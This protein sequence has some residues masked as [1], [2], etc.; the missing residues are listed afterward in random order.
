VHQGPFVVDL[1]TTGVVEP[2]ESHPVALPPGVWGGSVDALVPEGRQVKKGDF[3]ARVSNRRIVEQLLDK[4]DELAREQRGLERDRAD[5]PVKRWDVQQE[6]YDKQQAWRE[7][8]LNQQTALRGGAPEDVAAARRDVRLVDLT[9]ANDP[10][11][12]EERLFEKGIVSRQEL[13]NARR[14]HDVAELEKKRAAIALARLAPGALHEQVELARLDAGMAKAAYE[15]AKLEAPAKRDLIQVDLDKRK[16]R[17]KGLS[18]DVRRLQRKVDS[19][20]LNAPADG[21]LLYPLIWNWKKVHVGMQVWN[22]LNFLAVARLDAVKI[23]GAVTEAEIGRVAVGSK[24]EITTDAYPGR[25]FPG[26]VTLVSKLAK[27]ED[28]RRGEHV[29]GIKRFDVEIRPDG[30]TPE[31]KPNMRVGVRVLGQ[32][33]PAASSI[34]QEALFGDPNGRWIW[35][36]TAKGPEKRA[37]TAK[38][39]GPDWVALEQALPPGARVYLVDPTVDLAPEVKP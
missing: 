17:I 22:G 3:L 32:S 37:V 14:D 1:R 28:S 10:L 24:V 33:L 39:W 31:L 18:K 6:I 27:E 36:E 11:A 29:S 9:L 21:M 5:A 26:K 30:K 13:A 19:A 25:V 2:L 34:P 15:S 7:K 16:V 4:Q 35:L 38:L 20:T 12:V 8:A 23:K